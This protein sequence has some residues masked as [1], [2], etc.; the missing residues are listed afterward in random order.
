MMD[1]GKRDLPT[2]KGYFA[3][4]T[5]VSI[6]GLG[7]MTRAMGLV[8]ILT[9]TGLG[10]KDS[11]KMIANGVKGLKLG[12]MAPNTLE[13]IKMAINRGMVHTTGLM[14]LFT[15]VTGTPTA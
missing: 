3:I 9:Q 4:L 13:C 6:R 8:F 1:N 5:E 11:G 15:L 2:A 12:L 7:S 10:M 14:A